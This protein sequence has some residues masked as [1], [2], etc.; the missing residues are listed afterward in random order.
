MAPFSYDRLDPINRQFRLCMLHPGSLDGHF[1]CTL[2]TLSLDDNPEYETLSY[3]WG[4]PEFNEEIIVNDAYAFVTKNLH[5]ALCN[6]R[7]PDKPRVVWADGICINQNDIDERSSQVGM[8]GDIYRNST[9]LQIWLGTLESIKREADLCNMKSDFYLEKDLIQLKGFLE[10]HN[11]LTEPSTFISSGKT[12]TEIEFDGA[13]ET[14]QH[15]VDDRHFH[16]MPF[17]SVTSEIKIQLKPSWYHSLNLLLT[18]FSRPWWGRVWIVQ[19]V[20]LSSH[21]SVSIGPYKIDLSRFFLAAAAFAR[22]NNG[23]CASWSFL[24]SGSSRIFTQFLAATSLI[25]SLERNNQLYKRGVLRLHH[26]HEASVNRKALDPHDH[27]YGLLGLLSDPP[28]K[29]SNYRIT[30]SALYQEATLAVFLQTKSLYLLGKAVGT[31]DPNPHSLVSWT[32]DWSRGRGPW[33][34]RIR[35]LLYDASG[36]HQH[37]IAPQN[38]LA[39]TVEAAMIGN[40]SDLGTTIND[41]DD[42]ET[43]VFKLKQW[44]RELAGHKPPVKLE[45]VLRLAFLDALVNT[46]QHRRITSPDH[47]EAV[48]RWWEWIQVKKRRPA[49]TDGDELYLQ[50]SWFSQIM[51]I[52]RPFVT[53]QGLL[54]MGLRTVQRGDRICIAKGSKVPLVLRPHTLQNGYLFVG[55]CYLHGIM[56]GEAA[57]EDTNWDIIDLY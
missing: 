5:A 16:E 55:T 21:A 54:G 40:V 51:Q 38:D 15:L 14:F 25:K 37:R 24:W 1:S 23:C 50:E 20:I 34:F 46:D 52:Y 27:V 47:T 19:E 41:T 26:L 17:F 4:E 36:G 33:S 39:L 3:A 8:M 9:G 57:T 12:T 11:K 44:Q 28:I 29:V 48:R 6:L 13:L 43:V 32:C 10:Y 2:S 45:I 56:D 31:D 18:V 35:Y 49:R 7:R 22:H 42:V 53:D 30:I